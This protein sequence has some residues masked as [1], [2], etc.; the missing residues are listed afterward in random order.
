V[1]LEVIYASAVDDTTIP[2]EGREV[3]G[4]NRLGQEDRLD[5]STVVVD[6]CESMW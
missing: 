4:E 6:I 5:D 3:L 2:G 1:C